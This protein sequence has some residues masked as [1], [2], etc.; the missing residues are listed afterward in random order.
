VIRLLIAD[1][2]ALV[3]D[4]FRSILERDPDI[5]VVAEAQDGREAVDLATRHRPDVV[6]MDIRMPVLDGLEATKRVFGLPVPPRVVVLTTYDTDDNLHTALRLG[7]SG[8]LLKDIR[9]DQLIEAVH[10]VASGDALV[11]PS[12]VRRLVEGYVTS[13]PL[14]RTDDVLSA[15]SP[16]ERDVVGLVARGMSNAEIASELFL[17][18]ATVKTHVNRILTKLGLRDRVQVVVLAYEAGVVVP[19]R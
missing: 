11:S 14:A 6:L 15:L 19:G 17:S 10:S 5:Q 9:A 16:R 3:R 8:F 18:E 1:D 13:R 4:G 12:L 2:Q 7:A